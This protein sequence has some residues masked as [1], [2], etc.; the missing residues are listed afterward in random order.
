MHS[1][2]PFGLTAPIPI[3]G[4]PP[5]HAWQQAPHLQWSMQN[6]AA[7]L[8]TRPVPHGMRVTE[9]SASPW[10]VASIPVGH[11]W[12]DRIASFGDVMSA[13]YTDAWM[14]TKHGAIIDERY[15]GSMTGNSLHLLMSVSKSLTTA[16]AGTLLDTGELSPDL[17]VTAAVPALAASGYRGASVRD[18]IDMRTGIRFSEHYV[19]P[20]A[21]VRLLEQAI[22]WAPRRSA[23]TP[24]TLLDFLASLQAEREHGGVFDYKS[25]ETDTLAFVIE[26][27][28]GRHAADL[29]S[30]RIWKPMG[31]SESANVGVD[32]VGAGMFDGGVSAA[33]RDLARF[34]NLMV[35]EGY[36][37]DGMPVLPSWWVADTFAGGVDSNEAFAGS[38]DSMFMPGGMY[39][40]GFWFP[41]PNREVTLALGIHGQMIYMDRS[42]GFVGV[43]VSSWPEPQHGERLRWTI[44]AFERVASAL[45]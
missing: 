3:S 2:D 45:A 34:G 15:F 19:D 33:L 24:G 22:G 17:P 10:D 35:R 32:S 14:V 8:P 20:D 29:L 36:S 6:I 28:S 38:P 18:L 7:F 5:L 25:C 16:L 30:E 1:N 37:L 13:S 40:N 11:P 41:G 23:S 12:D 26:G 42:R 27:V 9:F 39:R 31:A 4:P 44:H 43:K 21:E